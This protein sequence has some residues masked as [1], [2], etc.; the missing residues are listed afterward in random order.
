MSSLTRNNYE[1][2]SVNI[3]SKSVT[4][5]EELGAGTEGGVYRIEGDP[6]SVAKVFDEG[7]R[8]KKADKV[9]AMINNP[10]T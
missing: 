3:G 5:G 8:N 10:P 6:S 1:G 7:Y 4:L 2:R 9:Q